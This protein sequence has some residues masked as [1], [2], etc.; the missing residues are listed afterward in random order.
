MVRNRPWVL[1]DYTSFLIDNIEPVPNAAW[2][3]SQFLQILCV[4]RIRNDTT[5][6][7]RIKR[8][9]VPAEGVC[10]NLGIAT[11]Q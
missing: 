9:A 11:A 8:N 7:H 1:T 6:R 2:H 10:Q 3:D 5:R 4:R